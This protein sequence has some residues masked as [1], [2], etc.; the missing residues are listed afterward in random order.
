M[1]GKKIP[2]IQDFELS[3]DSA[4]RVPT[5]VRPDRAFN[6]RR[7][8]DRV[9]TGENATFRA[10]PKLPL[11]PCQFLCPDEIR[12]VRLLRPGPRLQ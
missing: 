5:A 11:N 1:Q 9:R 12:G 6:H 10:L 2:V 7:H 8:S 3:G 4:N